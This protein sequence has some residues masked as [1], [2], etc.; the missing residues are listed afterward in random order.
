MGRGQ[1]N[2]DNP[3]QQRGAPV[4]PVRL[5]GGGAVDRRRAHDRDAD[6]PQDLRLC[7]GGVHLDM[8]P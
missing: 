7:V 8:S 5:D 1:W 4:P 3:G 6:D 2:F